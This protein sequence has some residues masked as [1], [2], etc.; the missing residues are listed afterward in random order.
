MS[1]TDPRTG[2]IVLE[3]DECW[4]LLREADV[5]RLAVTIGDHPD[6]FPI[7]HV[8]DGETVVFKTLDGT[9]LSGVVHGGPVAFEVDDYDAWTGDAWSVVVK[10]RAVEIDSAEGIRRAETLP[11]FA[12]WALP[13]A[14]WV[15]IRADDVSGRRFHVVAESQPPT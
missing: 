4:R 11:L 10:G 2:M 8:V 9:K 5:G 13:D 15:Q 3:A 7:N 14:R 6:I 1:S 12:W